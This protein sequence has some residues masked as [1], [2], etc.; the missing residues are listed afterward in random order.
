MSAWPRSKGCSCDKGKAASSYTSMGFAFGSTSQT[1]AYSSSKVCVSAARQTKRAPPSTPTS[2]AIIEGASGLMSVGAWILGLFPWE[3]PL[4]L[5]KNRLEF[6]SVLSIQNIEDFIQP[7]AS[8]ISVPFMSTIRPYADKLLISIGGLGTSP[9]FWS[10]LGKNHEYYAVL[11]GQLFSYLDIDGVEWMLAGNE[12]YATEELSALFSHVDAFQMLTLSADFSPKSI[13]GDLAQKPNIDRVT[14]RAFSRSSGIYPTWYQ[15][16]VVWTERI[17]PQKI[18]V[19][20]CIQSTPSMLNYVTRESLQSYT[21]PLSQMMGAAGVFF[22][23]F[24]PGLPG[25]PCLANLI[26]F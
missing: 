22:W 10:T 8:H 19:G 26:K 20:L 6:L 14:L 13:V 18:M 7:E 12:E 11:L 21:V 9:S 2:Q 23:Y 24:A 16:I 25:L 4:Y 17:H 15:D 5:P 3:A 1:S